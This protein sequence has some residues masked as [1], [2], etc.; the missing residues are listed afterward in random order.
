MR[1]RVSPHPSGLRPATFPEGEGFGKEK[2]LKIRMTGREVPE[3]FRDFD[4]LEI[5]GTTLLE[6]PSMEAQAGPLIVEIN[7]KGQWVAL[8]REVENSDH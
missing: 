7:N 6:Q 8:Y 1:G 3:E 2:I 4:R 5:E